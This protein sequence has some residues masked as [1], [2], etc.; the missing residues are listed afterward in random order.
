MGMGWG[1]EPAFHEVETNPDSVTGQR[2][3]VLNLC[4]VFLNTLLPKASL[5]DYVLSL[6]SHLRW[7][8]SA[9]FITLYYGP[10]C[11][12]SK[13]AALLLQMN[14]VPWLLGGM[15]TPF[16]AS[17]P[18]KA[19]YVFITHL[20][21]VGGKRSAVG[22]NGLICG[23]AYWC[24]WTGGAAQQELSARGPGEDVND[25]WFGVFFVPPSTVVRCFSTF[26]ILF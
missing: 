24:P 16:D 10:V 12:V 5:G 9:V 26:N 23:S 14:L 1:E 19:I 11:A 20:S 18:Q 13:L 4:K 17:G 21:P 22:W 2:C 25:L 6:F 8:F 3:Q 7:H 15:C